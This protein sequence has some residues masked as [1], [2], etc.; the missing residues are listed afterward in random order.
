MLN[1]GCRHSNAF[2]LIELLVVIAIIAIL[3]SMLL[4]ALAKAKAKAGKVKC[5]NNLKQIGT[6]MRTWASGKDDRLPWM[7]YRRYNIRVR[8]PNNNSYYYDMQNGGNSSWGQGSVGPRAW[9]A[10]YNFSN[11]LGSPKILMCPGNK[12]KK[13]AIA[14]DWTQGTVG[15]FNSTYQNSNGNTDGQDPL[16]RTERTKYGRMPG[17]DNS[18]AYMAVGTTVEANNTGTTPVGHSDV[19]LAMDFNVNGSANPSRSG[20]PNANPM[21]G[22]R[23]HTWSGSWRA[24]NKSEMARGGSAPGDD[25]PIESHELGFVKGTATSEEFA[26]HAEEG[27][28]AM[29][30]GSV[31]SPLVRADFEAM[32]VAFANALYGQRGNSAVWSN[33]PDR[34]CDFTAYQPY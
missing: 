2:T 10:F 12:M 31:S 26:H 33:R 17:Y 28:V 15:F 16:H 18:V 29:G 7:L 20:F 19:W 27:N 8:D 13:N 25:L 1:K 11:E 30:D 14:S 32:G 6:A 34:G 3:A 22:H 5:V 4:P 24:R 21:I 9:T 23:F